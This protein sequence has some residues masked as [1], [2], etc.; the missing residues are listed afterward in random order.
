[1]RAG[2]GQESVSN[3]ELCCENQEAINT[4]FSV[5]SWERDSY[6]ETDCINFCNWFPGIHF[7][8]EMCCI[9]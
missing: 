5:I 6:Q 3:D 9:C 8:D 2:S 7:P 4:R 1:M